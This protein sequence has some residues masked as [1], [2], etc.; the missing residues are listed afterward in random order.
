MRVTGLFRYPLKSGKVVS[1]QEAKVGVAGFEGDRE[2]MIIDDTTGMFVA[3]RSDSGLGVGIRSACQIQMIFRRDGLAGLRAPGMPDHW[4][5]MYNKDRAVQ[6]WKDVCQAWTTNHY[7]NDWLSVFLSR[8]R[9]GRYSLAHIA[10]G[11]IRRAKQG[12]SQLSFADAYPFLIASEDSLHDLNQRIVGEPIPMNRFRPGIVIAGGDPYAEDHFN[13][14]V[15]NGVCFEGTTLC[16]RCPT[17]ITNQST[18]ALGKEPLLTLST[19]RRGR[20]LTQH[21]GLDSNGVYF[22][23]NANHLSQGII[24]L[25]DKVEFI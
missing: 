22:A 2:Y 3:Q 21:E 24:R 13:R 8:E 6:V 10:P 18:A 23:R 5:I 1:L 20:H 14:M 17:V 25:G 4:D 9:P 15:I 19:Y 16:V 7:T 11:F 12:Y